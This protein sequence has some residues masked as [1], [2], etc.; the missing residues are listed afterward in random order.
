MLLEYI[1][2]EEQDVDIL[3]KAL[4]RCKFEFHKDKIG[5]ADNP[6]LIERECLQSQK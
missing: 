1:P 5:V 6:F 4:S 3:S 2:T